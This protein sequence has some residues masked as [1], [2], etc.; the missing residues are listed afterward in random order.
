MNT[1]IA[2]D[3]E[4]A[5][6]QRLSACCIGFCVYEN[7]QLK[8][9]GKHLFQPPKEHNTFLEFHETLHGIKSE[10]VATKPHFYQLWHQELR[11]TFLDQTLVCHNSS[12][13][14]SILNQLFEYYNILDPIPMIYDTMS[15]AKQYGLPG[16]IVDLVAHFGLE[17]IAH[18]DPEDDARICG[19]VYLKL[20]STDGFSLPSKE[21]KPSGN[22][23]KQYLSASDFADF[24]K[25]KVESK[26]LVKVLDGKNPDHIFYNKI[27][28]ITGV[29]KRFERQGLA[30]LLKAVGG[31]VNTSISKNTNF[32]LVGEGAGPSKL[33][34]IADLNAKGA[35]IRIL[36][37]EDFSGLI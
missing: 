7:G 5:N 10:M 1:F 22:Q 35:G 33:I 4:T 28:V 34:K 24:E 9:K 31:D 14:A 23:R 2:I 15:I 25:R 12:M 29:F 21:F 6:N 37:E 17:Q 20:M 32:V 18:H 8:K 11:E 16:K 30:E 26:T 19:E 3:F 27:C 36:Y 13:D